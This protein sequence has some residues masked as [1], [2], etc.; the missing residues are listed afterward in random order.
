[1]NSLN[2]RCCS[3]PLYDAL[4]AMDPL[5]SKGRTQEATTKAT[6]EE[7]H[8]KEG[9]RSVRRPPPRPPHPLS[10]APSGGGSP[11]Q[12]WSW[13]PEQPWRWGFAQM[14]VLYSLTDPCFEQ[15]TE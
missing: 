15:L 8:G 14:Q 12:P 13:F 4:Q 1:M 6:K 7:A 5:F 2:S 10:P 11:Y 9:E 3:H